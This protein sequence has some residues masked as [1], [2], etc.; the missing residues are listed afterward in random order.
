MP[1]GTLRISAPVWFASPNSVGVRADYQSRYPDVNLEMDLSGR[2]VNLVEE[3]SDLALRASR[4]L[5]DN[6]FARPVMSVPF[7][8]VG[9]PAYLGKSV[10]LSKSESWRCT[11]CYGTRLPPLIWNGE[12]LQTRR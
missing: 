10:A 3:G 7:Y 6:L 1:R 12:R 9:T 2:L 8:L 5:G 4:T 11:A